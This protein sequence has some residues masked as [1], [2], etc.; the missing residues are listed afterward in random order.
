MGQLTVEIVHTGII[1]GREVNLTLN[2]V[3]RIQHSDPAKA[4]SEENEKSGPTES[5][6]GNILFIF[7]TCWKRLNVAVMRACDAIIYKRVRP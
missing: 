3:R 6:N 7:T 1:D 5:T 4:T 2:G